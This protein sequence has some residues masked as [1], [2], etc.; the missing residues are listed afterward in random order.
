M[1]L[2]CVDLTA[3]KPSLLGRF[4]LLFLCYWLQD[5][6][7]LHLLRVQSNIVIRN[8]EKEWLDRYRL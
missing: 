7:L 5:L 3:P 6:L 4:R 2:K 1:P 8:I